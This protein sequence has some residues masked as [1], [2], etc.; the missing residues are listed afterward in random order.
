MRRRVVAPDRPPGGADGDAIAH[1]P[2]NAANDGPGA[3]AATPESSCLKPQHLG[4]NVVR[5]TDLS[6]NIA[7]WADYAGRFPLAKMRRPGKRMLQSAALLR[8][9]PAFLTRSRVGM[10]ARRRKERTGGTIGSA[11]AAL[12][13]TNGARDRQSLVLATRSPRPPQA[14]AGRGWRRSDPV[15]L[16]DGVPADIFLVRAVDGAVQGD[17]PNADH[18]HGAARRRRATAI[19]GVGFGRGER[20]T[21]AHSPRLQRT[22]AGIEVAVAVF[23]PARADFA[24][25]IDFAPQL[26]DRR[27]DANERGW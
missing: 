4:G 11:G 24:V 19:A 22:A 10:N 12:E 14:A 16:L 3:G 2:P 21:F 23:V 8:R 13:P 17:R 9:T 27:A 20:V 25:T 18:R 7:Q 1:S 15:V 5:F 6:L 26:L